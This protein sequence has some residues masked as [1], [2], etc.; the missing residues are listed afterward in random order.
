MYHFDCFQINYSFQIVP[1]HSRILNRA[2]MINYVNLS[3]FYY[4]NHKVPH[5]LISL[6]NRRYRNSNYYIKT[7]K[8]FEF[9]HNR[10]KFKKK[11]KGLLIFSCKNS[12]L[13]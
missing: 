9:K 11:P 5:N 13:H 10:A 6:F 8:I 7:I 4:L 2:L 3:F 1:K 12:Y